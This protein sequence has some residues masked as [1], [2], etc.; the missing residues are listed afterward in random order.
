ML[1]TKLK[2][3]SESH[4]DLR[5]I[6]LFQVIFVLANMGYTAIIS[7]VVFVCIELPWLLT[8]KLFMGLVTRPKQKAKQYVLNKIECIDIMREGKKNTLNRGSSLF[9]VKYKSVPA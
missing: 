9:R 7:A 8:E 1:I 6:L 2:K 5:K 4:N 3:I